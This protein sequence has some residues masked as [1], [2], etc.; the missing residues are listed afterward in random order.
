MDEAYKEMTQL[1]KSIADFF[2]KNKEIRDFSS[3]NMSRLLYVSEASLHRFAKKCGYRGYREL[4]FS[5]EKDLENEIKN[6]GREKN[7]SH[8]VGKIQEGYRSTVEETFRLINEEKLREIA[9]K[10][11]KK[12]RIFVYGI[13]GSGL[14]A[15]QF[16]MNFMKLGFD[17]TAV[18]EL[19][20]IALSAK[21]A[22]GDCAV[23]AI[24][25]GGETEVV[26]NALKA[27]KGN[28]AYTVFITSGNSETDKKLSDDIIK[29]AYFKNSDSGAKLSP[30][31]SML[32]IIDILYS[33][34]QANEEY[35]TKMREEVKTVK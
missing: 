5:Y 25:A 6:I 35:F 30:K 17:I 13:G 23:I 7:V 12:R 22:K 34:C 15:R 27:A 21:T 2:I 24:S 20:M 16:Q 11:N 14:V 10:L 26:I 1:E 33:Y 32:I 18:T 8:F 9:E 29:I 4:I 3:K 28:G 19:D 31:V